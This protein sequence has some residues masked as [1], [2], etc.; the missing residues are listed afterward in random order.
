MWLPDRRTD[1]D[2]QT[3]R[4]RTKWSLFVAMLRRRHKNR[5]YYSQILNCTCAGM[6]LKIQPLSSIQAKDRSLLL[7]TL[8]CNHP[9]CSLQETILVSV[10]VRFERNERPKHS[11][12][13]FQP[14]ML[15]LKQSPIT[16]PCI[17]TYC[18][19][20]WLQLALVRSTMSR[21]LLDA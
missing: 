14:L 4:R 21:S 20:W 13:S 8:T 7:V 6:V 15:S 10:G 9:F 17:P 11:S 12:W 16:E 3:N 18:W 19:T 5:P 1:T 2:R